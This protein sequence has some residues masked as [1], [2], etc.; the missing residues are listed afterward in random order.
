MS[1]RAII[2]NSSPERW[3]GLSGS[4]RCHADLTGVGFDIGNELG[5][6]RCRERR[7]DLHQK[8]RV[9][10]GGDRRNIANEIEVEL[11][12]KASR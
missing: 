7:I 2:L 9:H 11:S 6:G 12:D 1:M 4:R 8:W 3:T 10:D 5:H